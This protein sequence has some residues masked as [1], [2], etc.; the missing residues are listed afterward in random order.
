MVRSRLAAR[1]FKGGDK[2]RDD[3]FH[4]LRC[5]EFCFIFDLPFSSACIS[6]KYFSY[7]VIAKLACMTETYHVYAR[8]FGPQRFSSSFEF[9]VYNMSY[10]NKSI[11]AKNTIQH[12]AGYKY[13]S[14]RQIHNFQKSK[15]LANI[16]SFYN[17]YLFNIITP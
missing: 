7:S 4:F 13:I 8:R 17:C 6:H 1:D 3:L 5:P 10:F 12:I 11:A 15:Y 2:G 16:T 9:L 14:I